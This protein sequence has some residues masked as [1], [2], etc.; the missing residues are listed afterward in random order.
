MKMNKAPLTGDR[1]S[2]AEITMALSAL[3]LVRTAFSSQRSLM[4]WMRTSVSLY[5]FGFSITKFTEYLGQEGQDFED[6]GSPYLLGPILI[7]MG[8]VAI[9]LAVFE[10]TKR[11]RRMKQLGLPDVSRPYLPTIAAL[12]LL[13]I[14]IVTLV[15]I[16]RSWP[17]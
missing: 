6:S 8:I 17:V 11:I 14:G 7:A 5:T 9:V 13:V 2:T 4:A 10:H 15:G 1:S 16:A 3:A 12:A